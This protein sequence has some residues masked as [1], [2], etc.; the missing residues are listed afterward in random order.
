MTS[1]FPSSH[2][3]NEIDLLR[4]IAALSVTL[5]HYSFLGGF[6]GVSSGYSPLSPVF[7]YGFLGVPLFFI[8]SG[9]VILMSACNSDLK[10][11]F[12]SR[13]ARLYPA[14]W[15]CCTITFFVT[16]NSATS[17]TNSFFDYL[18]NMTM[19]NELLGI[20]SIDGSYWTLIIEI[21]FY[22]FISIILFFRKIHLVQIVMTIWLLACIVTLPFKNTIVG[23]FLLAE[24]APYFITGAILYLVW[25][26]GVSIGKVVILVFAWL[27][28]ILN[29]KGIISTLSY[30]S[31]IDTLLVQLVITCMYIAMTAVALKKTGWLNKI[32]FSRLGALTYPLYLIHQ[33]IGYLLFNAFNSKYNVHAVFW[34][35]LMLMIIAAFGISSFLEKPISYQLKTRLN[36]FLHTSS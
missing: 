34:G 31:K 25:R 18:V 20:V 22:F 10:R 17:N 3:V 1:E 5:F 27:L 32:D 7:I 6:I 9:F 15:I 8:I 16:R 26:D 23:S 19:L 36:R 14:F 29:S 12:I 24:Y 2:R 21:K 30:S 33:N 4:F 13:S 28:A 35:T 11:F